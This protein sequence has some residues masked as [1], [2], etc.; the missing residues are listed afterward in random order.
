MN[1]SKLLNEYRGMQDARASYQKKADVWKANIDTLTTE[2][3]DDVM[4]LD[5]EVQGLSAKEKQ[6]TEHLIQTKQKQLYDYQQALS[7]QAQEEDK[8]MTSAILEGI[9]D[10]L[11]KY[12]RAKGY[13]II[14]AVTEYGNIAY[15]DEG[16]DITDE[17]L[18]GLNA[19]Y[20]RK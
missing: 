9:N 10:Y 20:A 17:V 13:K 3:H 4:T 2:I 19:S 12:G 6:L 18:K 5:K 1:T 11:R 14:M 8:K 7:S 15:A 16:L